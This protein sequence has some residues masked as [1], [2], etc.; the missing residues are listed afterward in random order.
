LKN[1]DSRCLNTLIE[2]LHNV[3][4]VYHGHYL[5]LETPD[6]SRIHD[7]YVH[8][9]DEET[10]ILTEDG[11]KR[12]NELTYDD[13]VAT[14]N[15]EY[16][17]YHKP[18]KI[19]KKR[20][21]GKMFHVVSKQIDLC[22]TPNHKMYVSLSK[23]ANQWSDFQLIEA[24]KIFDKQVKYKKNAKWI[25]KEPEFFVLPP[26]KSK[27]HPHLNKEIRI[28]MKL[29]VKFFGYYIAEGYARDKTTTI[30]Q[31]KPKIKNKIRNIL[32]RLPWSFKEYDD[33]FVIYSKQ[34]SGYLKQFGLAYEKYLPKWFKQLS[35]SLLKDF[36]DCYWEGDGHRHIAT[37]SSKKLAD[38]LTEVLL[39]AG[40]SG[41]CSIYANKGKK[42]G[43]IQSRRIIH[44][45]TLYGVHKITYK[46]TPRV[47]HHKSFGSRNEW[48][49]YDGYVYCVTVPNHIIYVRRNG[50]PCWS[51]NSLALARYASEEKSHSLGIGNLN[52]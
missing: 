19:I 27:Y 15:D 48:I 21:K 47:L 4:R 37:T 17:E 9:Y 3:D 40:L 36:L 51:G 18:Q 13:K 30:A 42:G 20:Y 11:W 28:P 5:W 31:V 41:N 33:S 45:H 44:K 10:E 23:G 49:E 2:Q 46:N 32:Q 26:L 35:S 39:K 50:K 24:E 43:K 38:D 14:L 6:H 29:W 52:L 7:D 12:F 25:G 1:L 8:C 16:L 22:V 34:L